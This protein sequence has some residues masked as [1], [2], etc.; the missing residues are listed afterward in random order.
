MRLQDVFWRF[1]E[2]KYAVSIHRKT[3]LKITASLLFSLIPLHKVELGP[4]FL[5]LCMSTLELARGIPYKKATATAGAA[6]S[7]GRE[8]KVK[9]KNEVQVEVKEEIEVE[10][11]MAR[12]TVS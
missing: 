5:R 8:E 10:V 1:L 3:L 12:I 7:V 6:M 4:L 9:A 2:E 11:D